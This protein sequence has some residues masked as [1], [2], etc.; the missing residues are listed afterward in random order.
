MSSDRG[1]KRELSRQTQRF[2][3]RAEPRAILSEG[4]RSTT[5]M[6]KD[7]CESMQN[8]CEKCRLQMTPEFIIWSMRPGNLS[9][10]E[11][12]IAETVDGVG[13]QVPN[14]RSLL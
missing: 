13:W 10:G 2:Y 4:K 9:C 6:T 5:E 8:S 14:G 11:V 3:T 12:T 7:Y 1:T